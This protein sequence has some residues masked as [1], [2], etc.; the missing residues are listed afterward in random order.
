MEGRCRRL[1]IISRKRLLEAEKEHG[2]GIG[3]ALDAWYR[4]A[5]SAKWGSLHEVRQTYPSADGVPVEEKVFTVFNICGNNFRL[6]V[7]INYETQRVFVK[8][9]LTHAEYDKGD[10]KK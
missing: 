10:W 9:V 1:H 8:D 3:N 6:I 4:V 2:G 7:G 5:K